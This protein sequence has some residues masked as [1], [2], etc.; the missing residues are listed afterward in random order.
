MVPGCGGLE[1]VTSKLTVIESW[2]EASSTLNAQ[3]TLYHFILIGISALQGL[4]FSFT[5]EKT[6]APRGERLALASK[7]RG[8]PT[9]RV[10]AGGRGKIRAGD[11]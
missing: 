11:A 2:P 8:C 1:I 7:Q 6:E 5:D 4:L 3:H 9:H 10:M